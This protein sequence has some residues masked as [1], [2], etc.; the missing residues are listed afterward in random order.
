MSDLG[1]RTVPLAR[2]D[3]ILIESL[4]SEVLIYDLRTHEATCLN[5]SAALIWQL[6]DSERTIEDIVNELGNADVTER[7]VADIVDKLREKRLV[8]DDASPAARRAE[9]SKSRRSFLGNAAAVG[10][11]LPVVMSTTIPAAAQTAPFGTP[12]GGMSSGDPLC[13]GGLNPAQGNS[14]CCPF[15]PST[16][17]PDVP[18]GACCI[19]DS[20]ANSCGGL[21][22]NPAPAPCYNS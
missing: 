18:S 15:P 5:A 19:P 11:V 6:C 21:P 8:E 1:T 2:T 14:K 16:T 3:D 12:C 17:N 22:S 10:M 9:V 20:V 13:N 4:E 7:H